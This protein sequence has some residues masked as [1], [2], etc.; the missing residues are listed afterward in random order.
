MERKR[1]VTK[2]D[3]LGLGKIVETIAKAIPETTYRI[4]EIIR[5][6]NDNKTI[7]KLEAIRTNIELLNVKVIIARGCVKR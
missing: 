1:G 7:L 4:G 5:L 3:L 2:S 6:T